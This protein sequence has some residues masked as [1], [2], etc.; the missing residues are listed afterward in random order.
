L[1][2]VV[3]KNQKK[4]NSLNN[5]QEKK[6]RQLQ[7]SLSLSLFTTN[8]TTKKTSPHTESHPSFS[9]FSPQT[10]TGAMRASLLTFSSIT[11]LLLQLSIATSLALA[12]SSSSWPPLPPATSPHVGSDI[13]GHDLGNIDCN[14]EKNEKRKN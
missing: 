6:N 4:T 11:L 2:V 12:S 3:Q 7:L 9:N 14:R 10:T 1:S 8:T 5:R 13:P